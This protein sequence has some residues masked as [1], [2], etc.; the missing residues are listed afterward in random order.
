MPVRCRGVLFS[1][2]GVVCTQGETE[3]HPFYV[4]ITKFSPSE[5]DGLAP[6]LPV[7][8]LRWHVF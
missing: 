3:S 5:S 4:I 8:Q 2:S 6:F 1:L 7:D